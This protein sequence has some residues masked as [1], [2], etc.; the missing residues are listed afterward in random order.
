MPWRYGRRKPAG[1]RLRR[2]TLLEQEAAAMRFLARLWSNWI[3]LLGS[4][5][6]SVAALAILVVVG[7]DLTSALNPYFVT[8]AILLLPAA[9]VVGLALIPVGLYRERRRGRARG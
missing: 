8:L 9:F 6:T 5:I 2:G 4:A 3:T 1:S 7:L